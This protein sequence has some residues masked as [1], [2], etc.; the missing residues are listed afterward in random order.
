MTLLIS[1]GMF[2]AGFVLGWFL[3]NVRADRHCIRCTGRRW[4]RD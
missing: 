1:C 4:S 3:R 2:V